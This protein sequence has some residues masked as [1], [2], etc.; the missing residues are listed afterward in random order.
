MTVAMSRCLPPVLRV[1]A[2]ESDAV[3]RVVSPKENPGGEGRKMGHKRASELW[4]M[5]FPSDCNAGRLVVCNAVTTHNDEEASLLHYSNCAPSLK[6]RDIH[7]NNRADWKN[8]L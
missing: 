1:D 2:A 6:T 5:P 4:I 7:M 3:Y 8:S